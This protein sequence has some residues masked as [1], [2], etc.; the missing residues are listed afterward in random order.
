MPYV[1]FFSNSFFTIRTFYFCHNLRFKWFFN[2]FFYDI[3]G[4]YYLFVILK[5]FLFNILII[6]WESSFIRMSSLNIFRSILCFTEIIMSFKSWTENN[7]LTNITNFIRSFWFLLVNFLM[8]IFLLSLLIYL[9]FF[10]LTSFTNY[11][12]NC[13]L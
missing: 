4:R 10:I 1:S 11:A 5:S 12:F 8:F 7:F 6:S 3:F 13:R 9:S 2:W